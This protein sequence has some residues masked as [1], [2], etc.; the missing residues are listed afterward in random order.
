MAGLVP[1]AQDFT[2]QLIMLPHEWAGSAPHNAFAT[3]SAS[4]TLV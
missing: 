3:S 2:N 4:G 1:V